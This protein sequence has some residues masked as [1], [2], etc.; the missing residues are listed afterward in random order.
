M[1]Q[2]ELGGKCLAKSKEKERRFGSELGDGMWGDLD[3]IPL[4]DLLGQDIL[5]K[6]FITREG[7][8][9]NRETGQ[10]SRFAVILILFS[11]VDDPSSEKTTMCGA[12]VA[13]KRL[14]EAKDKGLLPLVGKI[15]K[16]DRYYNIV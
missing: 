10:Y 6:D 11:S 4:P 12:S 2:A 5:I 9:L 13:V 15:I 7:Q 16:D 1:R 14:Q 8:F 3:R